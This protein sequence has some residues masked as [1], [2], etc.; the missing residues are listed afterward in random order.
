MT[1]P[2]NVHQGC[3]SSLRVPVP[4]GARG[5]AGI[6]WKN[7]FPL[8]PQDRKGPAV[9]AGYYIPSLAKCFSSHLRVGPVIILIVDERSE[10]QRYAGAWPGLR[11]YIEVEL[12]FESAE[13]GLGFLCPSLLS[14]EVRGVWSSRWRT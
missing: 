12:G 8:P 6:S 10:T 11:G 5:A 3:L 2:G 14:E 1:S 4:Q 7:R 9:T 13:P